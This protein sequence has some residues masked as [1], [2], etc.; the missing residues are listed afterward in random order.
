LDIGTGDGSYVY[1]AALKNPHRF[2]IGLDANAENMA[3][4]A[5]KA[6]LPAKKGGVSNLL[7]V[8]VNAL[9]LPS[10][11]EGLVSSLTV[12]FPWGSLLSAVAKPEQEFLASIK[13]LARPKL[14]FNAMFSYEPN[15][16]KAVMEEFCLP[17]ISPE[18][19][20]K[21]EVEYARAGFRVTCRMV[22]QQ[23]LK[24]FPTSWAKRLGYGRP[25][26]CVE[27]SGR[28]VFS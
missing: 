3:A 11:L 13:K 23:E 12:L 20:N 5:H 26:P 4:Y 6:S 16:E 17:A 14:T 19:L 25:R 21:L 1:K 24:S 7:Y 22:P 15:V 9:A 18:T 10:E 8:V 28:V 27:I 2:Y